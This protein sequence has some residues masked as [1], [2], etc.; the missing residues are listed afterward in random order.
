MN[1]EDVHRIDDYIDNNE[2]QYDDIVED[3]MED[4]KDDKH[5][6]NNET[7]DIDAENMYNDNVRLDD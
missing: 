5:E 6:S 1:K 4:E 7:T 3:Y 2:V